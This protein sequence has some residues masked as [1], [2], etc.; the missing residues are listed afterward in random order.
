MRPKRESWSP[1]DFYEAAHVPAADDQTALSIEIPELSATLYPYQKKTIQW[2]LKREGVCWNVSGPDSVSSIEDLPAPQDADG[3]YS[4]RKHAEQS[5]RGGILAE[6]MGLG[7]TIEIIGL[8][9]LHRRSLTEKVV[10]TGEGEE[11]L[12][13]GATL[14]VTPDSLRQQWMEELERHAP[15]LKVRYYPGR[16]H[17]KTDAE[18]ELRVDLASQDVVITTYPILSAEVHFAMKPPE[19]SRRQERK[20][21]RLE[22]PLTKISWWRVC[23]DEA[24][25]IES[26]VTGAAAVA[27]V[28]PRINAWG[29]T[30]TPVK[31]DVKDLYGLLEFLRYEPYASWSDTKLR[32]RH[33]SDS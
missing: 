14:I 7:K 31:N 9:T 11:L 32:Y 15:H 2:L 30:G 27:R 6:E 16:K 21:E 13:T 26:G 29:V 24:Q 10:Y 20:Y 33:K 19:R 3:A 25:M 17:V 12:T 28:L 22:S 5:V 23:L 4:F 18:E 1:L 8:I